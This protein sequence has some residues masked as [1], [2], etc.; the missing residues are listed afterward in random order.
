MTLDDTP[1]V[2]VALTI[3]VGFLAHESWRE[4]GVLCRNG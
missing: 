3:V 2:L 1:A 4:G